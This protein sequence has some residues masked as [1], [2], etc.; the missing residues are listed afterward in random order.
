M[1][2]FFFYLIAQ[3]V[4]FL[5][6]SFFLLFRN[7]GEGARWVIRQMPAVEATVAGYVQTYTP[8]L[9]EVWTTLA[10]PFMNSPDKEE[11]P[12]PT[13]APP[14][15]RRFGPETSADE[16]GA[17]KRTE[18]F[19]GGT[20]QAIGRSA[21][22]PIDLA[23]IESLALAMESSGITPREAVITLSMPIAPPA[24]EGLPDR[25]RQSAAERL[26][27]TH[28]RAITGQDAAEKAVIRGEGQ[29]HFGFLR[30]DDGKGG[31]LDLMVQME[32]ERAHLTAI[33][34][35]PLPAL[36]ASDCLT[37]L[38]RLADG[39]RHSEF[40][41]TVQGTRPGLL[42]LEEQEQTIRR[43]LERLQAQTLRVATK[44]A[45]IVSAYCP[46]F[47]GGIAMGEENLNLQA[48][49]RYHGVDQNTHFAFAYPMLLQE[50]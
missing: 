22:M 40:S 19:A 23:L 3:V 42:A 33:L 34:R 10:P 46:R 11:F 44:E 17:P 18:V 43:C 29:G 36:K 27:Q 32:A 4:L 31:R 16:K 35:S 26:L 15:H 5:L 45:V 25:E 38:Y 2:K 20:E 9:M 28:F 39:Q 41:L 24:A 6:L 49:A 1:L 8:S 13:E 14:L 12:E 47:P 37:R 21:G 7:G 30:G 48:M 50:M